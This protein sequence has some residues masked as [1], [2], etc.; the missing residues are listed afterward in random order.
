[1]SI[2]WVERQEEHDY[3]KAASVIRIGI[4]TDSKD[5]GEFTFEIDYIKFT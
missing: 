3:D 2:E 1:M 5:A 4:I